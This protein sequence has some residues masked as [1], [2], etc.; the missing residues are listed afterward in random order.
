ML[1]PF[2]PDES[3]PALRHVE[4][5]PFTADARY[6]THKVR[7][8]QMRHINSELASPEGR[9]DAAGDAPTCGGTDS[10]TCPSHAEQPA[11]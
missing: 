5:H 9:L 7:I 8:A 3:S 6:R 2:V 1:V 4:E 10:R 11:E